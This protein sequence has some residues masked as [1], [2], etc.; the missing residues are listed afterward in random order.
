MCIYIYILTT[1]PTKRDIDK[2]DPT[3]VNTTKYTAVPKAV[4]L[5]TGA[6]PGGVE[7]MTVAMILGHISPVAT[8][9]NINNALGRSSNEPGLFILLLSSE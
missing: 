6:S 5:K 2:N 9:N 3:N 4:L 1:A 8:S 7:S